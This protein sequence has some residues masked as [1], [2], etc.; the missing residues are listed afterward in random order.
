VELTYLH[1]AGLCLPNE[2]AHDVVR[3]TE[4]DPLE[5]QIVGQVGRTDVALAQRCLQL[6]SIEPAS[7]QRPSER[8]QG[9]QSIPGGLEDGLLVLLKVAPVAERQ[10]LLQ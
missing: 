10:A 4:G 6:V 2:A 7:T 5:H 9:L 1:A 3:L 8:P